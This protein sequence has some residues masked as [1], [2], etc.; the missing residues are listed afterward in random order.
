[1]FLE[2]SGFT[3]SATISWPLRDADGPF[4]IHPLTIWFLNSFQ[5]QVRKVRFN[6]FNWAWLLGNSV[7]ILGSFLWICPSSLWEW[8]VRKEQ[9]ERRVLGWPL[10]WGKDILRGAAAWLGLSK[11]HTLCS[12]NESFFVG[13]CPLHLVLS[14]TL[15]GAGVRKASHCRDLWSQLK[16]YIL[17]NMTNIM[18]NMTC[19]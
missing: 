11:N 5:S 2:S 14:G 16:Y 15:L 4:F 18:Y 17:P 3:Y 10:V 1:M 13:P 9:G 19:S 6:E 7:L 8:Q 12:H